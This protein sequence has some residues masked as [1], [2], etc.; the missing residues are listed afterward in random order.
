[1]QEGWKKTRKEGKTKRMSVCGWV[2]E[3]EGVGVGGPSPLIL[4]E[5]TPHSRSEGPKGKGRAG[6]GGTGG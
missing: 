2:G 6:Q 3:S 4:P 1:M 5:L